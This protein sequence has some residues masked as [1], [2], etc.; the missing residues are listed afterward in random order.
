MRHG[1]MP[2]TLHVDAPTPQVDWSSGAVSLLTANMPWREDGGPRRAGVSSF[3]ISGTNAHVVLEAPAGSEVGVERG[4]EDPGG[5][6][7]WVLSGKSAGA[8]AGAAVR[9]GA[10]VVADP[11]LRVVD[12]AR[13]LAMTRSVFEYR[14]VVVGSGRAELLA[15]L[16]AVASGAVGVVSGPGGEGAGRGRELMLSV[17]EDFVQGLAV[18]WELVFAGTG[19]RSADLPTYP[20]QRTR[21]WLASAPSVAGGPESAGQH[22]LDHPLLSTVMR[23][24]G[25][26]EYVFSGRLTDEAQ[27]WLANHKVAGT[28]LLPGT[29]FVEIALRAGEQVGCAVLHELGVTAP[30]LPPPSGGVGLQVLVGSPDEDGRRPV[31]I[32]SRPEWGAPDGDTPWTLHATGLLAAEPAEPAGSVDAQPTSAEW[33]PEGSSPVDVTGL[34]ERLARRGYHY[35]PAFRG[36]TRAWQRD[37]EVFAEVVLAAAEQSEAGRY[38][39]HPALLDA[40]LHTIGLAAGPADETPAML[41]F[42]WRGVR[43]AGRGAD[44]LRVRLTGS[45]GSEAAL[46]AHDAAGRPVATIASVTLRPAPDDLMSARPSAGAGSL[47]RLRWPEQTA[48]ADVVAARWAVLGADGPDGFDGLGLDGPAVA[49]PVRH[50][51][52]LAD[53]RD[54]LDAGDPAPDLVCAVCPPQPG[55]PPADAARTTTAW[56]LALAQDWLADTRF[57]HARLVLVTRSAVAAA[58]GDAPD[59]AAAAVWGLLRSAQTEHPDRFVLADLD[60]TEASTQALPAAAAGTEPQIALRAGTVRVPRLAPVTAPTPAAAAAAASVE[61]HGIPEPDGVLR[62]PGL[63]PA[64]A[65]PAAAAASADAHRAVDPEGTVLVPPVAPP[66]AEVV[67]PVS[68]DAHRTPDPDGTVRV[69][70]LAPVAAPTAAAATPA[71]PE[72][73]SAE[74]H[75]ALDP[76]G[77]V[78]ITGGT[79]LL[80]GLVARR[81]VTAHGARRLLL[82]SR[83]GVDAEGAPALA[84][85]LAG[86]GAEVTVAACDVSEE[87]RLAALLAAI[88]VDRPLTAVVH[89]AGVLD[90]V[91]VGSLTPDRLD[92]VMRPKADA[93][94]RL[95][96]LTRGLEL[97]AFV[98]FSSV[99]GL[100]GSA[101]QGN[102]A[103]AN[104]FLDALAERRRAEGL[105][106]TSLAWG[107]WQER[108]ELTAGLGES[109][110]LRLS[111]IGVRPLPT[112]EALALFDA[113]LAADEPVLAPVRLDP[114]GL[115]GPE[116]P[117]PALLRAL[118]VTSPVSRTPRVPARRTPAAAEGLAG[119][120]RAMGAAE[121]TRTLSALVRGEAAA[122]LGLESP[123]DVQDRRAFAEL[124]MDS[125]TALELRNRLAALTGLALP[126]GLAFD[127]PTARDLTDHL[128]SELLGT[129]Q[130]PEASAPVPA[131]ADE[132]IAIVG[133]ACRYPGGVSSPQDLWSL[134]A[135]G[136]D[137]IGDFPSDRGWDLDGLFDP[138]P[139]RRGTSYARAGGFVDHADRFDAEFFGISPREA[140]AMDPQQRLLLETSWEAVERAGID[141]SALR[142]SRTGVFAGVMYHDYGSWMSTVPEEVEGY[143]GSGTAGSLASGRVAYVLGLEGPAISVDTACSSSLVAL[144]L[145][146]GALRSGECS[147]ALAGGVTVMSSPGV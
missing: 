47:Y 71:P 122:V 3:G 128:E 76:G 94:W 42:V 125:L 30:L 58:P 123:D 63:A 129:E 10:W 15:G 109:D 98:L 104:A 90:D 69:A 2:K 135:R 51:A 110:L 91:P 22:P 142:G 81:L 27:P 48:V 127:H 75:R 80:G 73:A 66:T 85:E 26:D 86:L 120:A 9:L 68:A 53:L 32:F 108:S 52:S 147:L 16:E 92:R 112:D 14:A 72:G 49:P 57:R 107:L 134:V 126:A 137:A 7:V 141:P 106:A 60:D 145:A 99:A 31:R 6:V 18:D 77:T 61:R 37:G 95:H 146:V 138:D 34:Y 143:V 12:V 136:G 84:E 38:R 133:M 121:R 44:T 35:G 55:R 88:P 113:A 118:T 119:R 13:G 41:P 74:P 17:A 103:A 56:A 78:L 139:D 132:P 131:T 97:S 100:F 23:L 65:P 102:Y 50:H 64:A 21:H 82:V 29:A 45:R 36:L 114:D 105:P 140:L 19:A 20:F 43:T 25:S 28:V 116:R 93:A 124:G 83:R 24:A 5:A 40:A 33:P 96:E 111:A 144:H 8:L 70:G 4:A 11:G 117:V 62:V 39:L 89:C 46:T 59:P 101:G 54:A 115:G 1:V 79:G 130:P 87:G 67:A